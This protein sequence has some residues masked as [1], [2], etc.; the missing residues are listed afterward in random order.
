MLKIL[1]SR[2]TGQISTKL[3]TEH[4]WVKGIQVCLNSGSHPFPRGDDNEIAKIHC[5]TL[6]IF[7]RTTGPIST[8]LS[9]K[10]PWVKGI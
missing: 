2:I 3:G 7:L 1:F 10:H 9:T 5:Q 6:Q 4:S 8:K